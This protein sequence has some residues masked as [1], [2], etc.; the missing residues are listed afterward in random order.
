MLMSTGKCDQVVFKSLPAKAHRLYREAFKRG[1]NSKKVQTDDRV[2]LAQRYE[3]YLQLLASGKTSIKSTGTQPH[4]LIVPYLRNPDSQELDLTIEGD[5]SIL[6]SIQL[7]EFS[8][9]TVAFSREEK[10]IT[11]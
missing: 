8:S 6:S 7:A 4:E 1:K 2:A 3:Q 5:L 9:N 11:R 10:L